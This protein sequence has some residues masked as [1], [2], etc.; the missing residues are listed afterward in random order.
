[1]SARRGSRR[2]P[3]G[4]VRVRLLNNH[5]RLFS[6]SLCRLLSLKMFDNACRPALGTKAR[7]G[8]YS[9]MSSKFGHYRV[10]AEECCLNA[11]KVEG[12]SRRIHWLEAASRWVTLGRQ[13]GA[14]L[15][16]SDAAT[17]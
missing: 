2:S 11:V 6:N 7:L 15:T 10:C 4:F 14:V 9:C 16:T 13:E 12:N 3:V 1:M 5:F 17:V 8:S